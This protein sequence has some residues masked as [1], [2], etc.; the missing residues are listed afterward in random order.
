MERGVERGRGVENGER[1]RWVEN[2]ERGREWR[3]G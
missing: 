2:G 3:E 1:G